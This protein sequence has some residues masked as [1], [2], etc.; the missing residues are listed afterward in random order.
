MYMCF[1]ASQDRFRD[2][3]GL[4][5]RVLISKLYLRD[6][7]PQMDQRNTSSSVNKPR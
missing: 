2:F 7:I 6:R 4:G 1:Y 3:R 5:G